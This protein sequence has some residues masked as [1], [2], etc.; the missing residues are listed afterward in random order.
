M[1]YAPCVGATVHRFSRERALAGPLVAVSNAESQ[2][3]W[4]TV[5]YVTAMGFD[6][7]NRA[8]QFDMAYNVTNENG[9]MESSVISVPLLAILPVPAI[10]VI[11]FLFQ[12]LRT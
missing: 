11:L 3:A 12:S 4:S 5:E 8:L 2:A 10:K 9:T 1:F 6:P 7:M